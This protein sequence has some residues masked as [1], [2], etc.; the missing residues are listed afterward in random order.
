M[1]IFSI[2]EVELYEL[3]ILFREKLNCK[4]KKKY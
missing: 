4:N 3:L 1:F 2:E